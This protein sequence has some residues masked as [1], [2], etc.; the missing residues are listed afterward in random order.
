MQVQ[1]QSSKRRGARG[2]G[3]VLIA[4]GLALLVLLGAAL[5]S[6]ALPAI[7][8]RLLGFEAI[9][10]TASPAAP[11]TSAAVA[12]LANAVK[13]LS[14]TFISGDYGPL[15]LPPSVDPQASIGQ[16]AAGVRALHVA[17]RDRDLQKLCLHFTG[18]CSARGSPVRQAQVL[19]GG[20]R[21][22]VR[23]EAYL[24]LINRWQAIEIMLEANSGNQL[25]IAS[26]SLGGTRYALPDNALGRRLRAFETEVARMLEQLQ[27]ASSGEVFSFAGF[28]LR[29]N[30][31]SLI[32]R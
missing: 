20:G 26:I 1:R 3:I 8:L 5:L 31:L 25:R 13:G 10:Q 22:T 24:D 2:C 7:A 32:F 9:R 18:F 19:V 16:D 21:I 14:V 6:P 27:A 12:T 4:T 30:Q 15:A 23:G 17:L 29:D 28:D 11:A